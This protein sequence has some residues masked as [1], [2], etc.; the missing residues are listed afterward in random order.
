M[1]NALIRGLACTLASSLVACTSSNDTPN[2]IDASV[3]GDTATT[4]VDQEIG[5]ETSIDAG[6]PMSFIVDGQGR[7]MIFHGMNVMG[8]SKNT[9]DRLPPFAASDAARIAG[10]GMNF[11]R[12]LVL[13]DAIEPTEGTYDDVYLGKVRGMLDLLGAQGI[14]VMI[15]FHQDVYAQKFC[16]DGA[17]AWAIHDDGQP[18]T[19]QTS[20]W[21]SNYF[22]PAVTRA[23]DNFWS[24]STAQKELQD[25]YVAMIAHVAKVL[26]DHPAVIGYDVINEPYP[27]TPFDLA[28]ALLGRDEDDGGPDSIFDR[29]LFADFYNRAIA[30][31]RS[32]D[33]DHYI[34]LEPRFGA[35]ANGSPSWMPQFTDPRSGEARIVVAP[36]LYSV[37]AESSDHYDVDDPTIS[38]WETQRR[39]D[40]GR[41]GEPL[42]IGEFGFDYTMPRG[43]QYMDDV[44]SMADRMMIGWSYWAYDPNGTWSPWNSTTGA[45]NPNVGQMTRA[46]PRR[47]AGTPTSWSY[48]ATAPTFDLAFTDRAGVTGPTEIWL[49]ASV[50]PIGATVTGS[51]DAATVT[52]TFDATKHVQLV[53]TPNTGGAHSLHLA[54]K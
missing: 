9:P 13:W 32:V 31:I 17:P 22:Q 48:D 34:F 5:D 12:Y 47:T 44:M 16:C 28:E 40:V 8:A 35:P 54:R 41:T 26:G 14:S 10:W 27:G 33:S 29:G 36:H 51:D 37:A 53:T 23:F 42:L 49:P 2:A 25:H 43:P 4:D 20:T 50:F 18:F 45:D 15:D 6:L 3:V 38:R 30:S 1:A 19:L 7:A 21:S 52:T 46:F 39:V 11:A 24:Y